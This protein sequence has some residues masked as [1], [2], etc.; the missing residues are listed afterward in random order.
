[1]NKIVELNQQEISAVSGGGGIMPLV[2]ATVVI[3][4]GCTYLIA[5]HDAVK[6]VYNEYAVPAVTYVRS[7]ATELVRKFAKMMETIRDFAGL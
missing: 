4:A 7:S 1:M 3:V 6:K 2:S 5:H